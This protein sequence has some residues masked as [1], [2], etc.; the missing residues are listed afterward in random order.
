MTGK[1]S[2]EDGYAS[3]PGVEDM[4]AACE[5][6]TA[7]RRVLATSERTQIVLMSIP[8]NTDIGAEVHKVDQTIVFVAGEGYADLDG[9]R[10]KMGP[11]WIAFVPKGTRHNFINTGMGDLKLYT[12]YAPPNHKPGDVEKTK[13][14]AAKVPDVPLHSGRTFALPRRDAWYYQ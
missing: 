2:D 14:D 10:T 7:W 5:K 4:V 11:G 6:N 1:L 3:A 8:V 13:A 12:V 9:S